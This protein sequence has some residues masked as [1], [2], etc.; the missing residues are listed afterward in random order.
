MGSD[1]QA[2]FWDAFAAGGHKVAAGESPTGPWPVQ[3]HVVVQDVPR[4]VAGAAVRARCAG[5]PAW[6]PVVDF[7]GVAHASISVSD[8]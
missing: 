7:V 3:L 4:V 6:Q 8:G 5:R 2:A 1:A